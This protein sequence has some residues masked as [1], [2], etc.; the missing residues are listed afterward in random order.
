[1]KGRSLK[2]ILLTSVA[3]ILMTSVPDIFAEEERK[4]LLGAASDLAHG[5]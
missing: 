4:A 3:S 1:M 2:A 5:N